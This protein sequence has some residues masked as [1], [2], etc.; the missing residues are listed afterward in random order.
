MARKCQVRDPQKEST[1]QW[2]Q[3][4]SLGLRCDEAL[5]AE[6]RAFLLWFTLQTRSR[7]TMECCA[8][9]LVA[10]LC[11]THSDPMDYSLP[12]SS[13]RGNLQAGILDLQEYWVALPSFRGSSQPRDR[14]LHCRWILY[15]LSH[16]RSP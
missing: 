15:H 9:G 5:L 1:F 7:S 6:N 13:V 4:L 12:G 16:Q 2:E 11:P 14:T 10:Q 8:M 3:I